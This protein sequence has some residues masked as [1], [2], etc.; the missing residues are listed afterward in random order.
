[1]EVVIR[2]L[3]NDGLICCTPGAI[4]GVDHQGLE[5][6]ERECYRIVRDHYERLPARAFD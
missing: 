6:A 5:T 2:K 1:M 4:T 3:E